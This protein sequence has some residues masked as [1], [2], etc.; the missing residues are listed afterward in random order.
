MALAIAVLG[1]LADSVQRNF[2]DMIV[3]KAFG[4]L[5]S[6]NPAAQPAAQP[7]ELSPQQKKK[8]QFIDLAKQMKSADCFESSMKLY[9]DLANIM[10][11]MFE[12]MS[13]HEKA[14][15]EV[16]QFHA[17]EAMGVV[18]AERTDEHEQALVSSQAICRCLRCIELF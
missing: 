15:L 18:V 12:F 16:V 9:S 10:K 11:T 7:R 3:T 8:N 17:Q 14:K 4:A 6:L 1:M 13:W 5:Y 2:V